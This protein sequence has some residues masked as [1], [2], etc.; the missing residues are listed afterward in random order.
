MQQTNSK[1]TEVV[2]EAKGDSA[3]TIERSNSS[4][5]LYKTPPDNMSEDEKQ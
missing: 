3:P 1:I 5:G 2:E 4:D